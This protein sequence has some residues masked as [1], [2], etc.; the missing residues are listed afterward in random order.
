[1]AATPRGKGS[2]IHV[3]ALGFAFLATLLFALVNSV[4]EQL[5]TLSFTLGA[6]IAAVISQLPGIIVGFLSSRG[7]SKVTAA[8]LIPA[9]FIAAT[10]LLAYLVY[11]FNGKADSL[12]S[13]AHMHVIM[14]PILHCVVAGVAYAFAVAVLIIAIV[15][16]KL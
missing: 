8:L 9:Y 5:P 2:P 16:S 6:T 3:A 14:F 15:A 4:G 7:I 12:N 1:M 10:G 13:A 11:A